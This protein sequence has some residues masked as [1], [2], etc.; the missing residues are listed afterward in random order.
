[1]GAESVEER[2]QRRVHT[3]REVRELERESKIHADEERPRH[4]EVKDCD[5]YLDRR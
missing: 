1:M 4:R 2:E 3:E 5:T